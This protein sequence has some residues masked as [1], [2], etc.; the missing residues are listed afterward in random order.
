MIFSTPR[1]VAQSFHFNELI[2]MTTSKNA[3]E[4]KMILKG[5]RVIEHSENFSYHYIINKGSNPDEENFT[6][7][8]PF[9]KISKTDNT[10]FLGDEK[11]KI[12]K[13]SIGFNY[14]G[15]F[16][17]GYVAS[18]QGAKT[19][20]E[21]IEQSTE[22]VIGPIMRNMWGDEI[23]LV[24]QYSVLDE[25]LKVVSEI[26][27]VS[28]YIGIENEDDHIYQKFE[29]NGFSILCEQKDEVQFIQIIK[30]LK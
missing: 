30:E 3:F 15:R 7:E 18:N 10:A 26:N 9:T 11:I 27:T 17:E 22:S 5:N 1:S 19:W 28:K 4:K 8:P 29:Y 6:L 23:K 20:Y 21:R 12:I 13:Y 2:E 24:V 25:Y 16:A 14:N